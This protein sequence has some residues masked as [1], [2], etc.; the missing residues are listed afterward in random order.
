MQSVESA[1]DSLHP[2]LVITNCHCL[3][4][5]TMKNCSHIRFIPTSENTSQRQQV[6]RK[7]Y[8]SFN[9][10]ATQTDRK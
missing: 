2:N 5:I 7:K 10:Y 4:L 6:S 1:S 3:H 8:Y 9:H